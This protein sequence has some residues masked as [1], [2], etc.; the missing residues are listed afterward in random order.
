MWVCAS[1]C[2]VA[3]SPHREQTLAGFVREMRRESAA[4]AL[5]IARVKRGELSRN[6]RYAADIVGKKNPR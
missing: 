2:A 4:F 6:L 3:R 1:G 5:S